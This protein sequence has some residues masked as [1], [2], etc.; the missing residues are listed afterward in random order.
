MLICICLYSCCMFMYSFDCLTVRLNLTI[1]QCNT[2]SSSSSSLYLASSSQP[3]SSRSHGSSRPNTKL[4]Q[5]SRS[6]HKISRTQTLIRPSLYYDRRSSSICL[7]PSVRLYAYLSVCVAVRMS[8][9][10]EYCISCWL[11][12]CSSC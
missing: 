11:Y 2:S 12:C 7:R 9:H 10:S 4:L 6:F 8:I 5:T 1:I 3:S